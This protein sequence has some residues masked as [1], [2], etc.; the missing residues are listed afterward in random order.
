MFANMSLHGQLHH[1]PP[2][3]RIHLL[4]NPMCGNDQ[5][6]AACLPWHKLQRLKNQTA[7]SHQPAP[8][9]HMP[10]SRDEMAACRATKGD[11][12]A[13][14]YTLL[15]PNMMLIWHHI[16]HHAQTFRSTCLAP[17]QY[18]DLTCHS[19]SSQRNQPFGELDLLFLSLSSSA[20]PSPSSSL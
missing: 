14:S 16:L 1:I 10:C 12:Q 8:A 15:G 20:S 5:M 17:Y 19:S 13:V 7:G 2:H 11:E 4:L 3:T 6:Q 9:M 18:Q